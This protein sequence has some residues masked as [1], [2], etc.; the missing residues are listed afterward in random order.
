MLIWRLEHA[1]TLKL[2][3]GLPCV[4]DRSG[5][6]E[7][8]LPMPCPDETDF[9][10]LARTEFKAPRYRFERPAE[11]DDDRGNWPRGML[12]EWYPPGVRVYAPPRQPGL[13]DTGWNVPRKFKGK[14]PD[15]WWFS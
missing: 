13:F 11:H 14:D 12:P 15:K 1:G 4:V 6:S 9:F 10:R 7:Q 3:M 2:H 5:V 8:L